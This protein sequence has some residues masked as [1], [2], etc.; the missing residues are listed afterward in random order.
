MIL[1]SLYKQFLK[2]VKGRRRQH[3]PSS[4]VG[5]YCVLEHLAGIFLSLT[6]GLW[7][8]TDA[9]CIFAFTK[10]GLER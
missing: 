9:I 8:G 4:T 1:W 5:T 7:K 3:L 6:S 10:R 2:S